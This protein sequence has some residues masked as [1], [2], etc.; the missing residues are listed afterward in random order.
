MKLDKSNNETE[1]FESIYFTPVEE[2]IDAFDQEK[3]KFLQQCIAALNERDTSLIILY[4]DDLPYKEISF[5]TGLSENHI[6]VKMKR[7]RNKLLACITQK[8]E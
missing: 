7:I 6:A 1:R 3:F 4:L 2:E 5:I 8:L